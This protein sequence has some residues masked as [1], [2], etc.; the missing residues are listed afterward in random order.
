ML[1]DIQALAKLKHLVPQIAAGTSHKACKFS[2][3]M[4]V[5]KLQYT[6]RSELVSKM[7]R[8]INRDNFVNTDPIPALHLCCA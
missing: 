2:I 4:L 6:M 7:L 1:H 8:Q 5:K 3:K